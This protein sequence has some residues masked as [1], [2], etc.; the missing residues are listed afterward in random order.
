LAADFLQLRGPQ[1]SSNSLKSLSP[2]VASIL[3]HNFRSSRRRSP[4]DPSER[5][6]REL[7]YDLETVYVGQTCLSWEFLRWQYEQARDLPESDPYHSHQY[8]QVAGEFQ[9]FQVVVQRF[10]EDESFKGPRLPNYI[11]N[12]CVL[13]SLLQ[14][15]VI[16]G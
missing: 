1:Q 14:V 10:V 6:L 15:P 3:S 9:Q 7:R 12:R 2:T 13:R 8:N 4:E 16:K 11:N 5:F